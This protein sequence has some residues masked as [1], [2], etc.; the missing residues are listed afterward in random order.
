M[1]A[2]YDK[3]L[4]IIGALA[5]AAGIGIY[6]A[7]AGSPGPEAAGPQVTGIEP[8]GGAYEPL[9]V[10][11]VEAETSAW[12]DPVPQDEQGYEV[13]HIFTPPK[14]WYDP[15]AGEFI[16]NP[17]EPPTPPPA[18]GI[19]L[20]AVER[21]PY[22]VQLKGYIEAASGDFDD[23]NILLDVY[24]NPTSPPSTINTAQIGDEYPELGIRILD[25]ENALV[26]NPDGTVTRVPTLRLYDR[27]RDE[28]IILTST[29]RRFIEGAYIVRFYQA[30]N[31]S[32]R[33]VTT[34]TGTS[35]QFGDNTYTLLDFDFDNQSA[36]VEKSAPDLEAPRVEQL[37]ATG[38]PGQTGNR[39]ENTADGGSTPQD[40]QNSEPG[41]AATGDPAA[42]AFEG[43][44]F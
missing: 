22:R 39:T 32:N 38:Q 2:F 29:E 12:P 30:D 6:F 31:P 36:T 40:E 19:K 16:F 26:E 20:I 3:L 18:F 10:P 4:L 43:F 28:E 5:L 1:Q 21:Q 35:R 14:I 27:L 34:E 37:S 44:N 24:T 15:E 33:W 9:P 25:F 7:K 17:P 13:Y 41:D 42:E 11:D 23:A 8:R